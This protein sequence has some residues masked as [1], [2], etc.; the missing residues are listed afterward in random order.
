MEVQV[1][2]SLGIFPAYIRA[3]VLRLRAYVRV[4]RGN[5]FGRSHDA[6]HH[7]LDASIIQGAGQD[8]DS[9]SNTGCR[10][11]VRPFF[12]PGVASE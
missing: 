8:M 7:G 12:F 10:G 1:L 11:S 5:R 6:C 3:A 2:P 4:R 9:I